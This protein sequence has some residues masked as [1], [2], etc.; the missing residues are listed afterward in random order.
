M[1]ARNRRA[2]RGIV[3]IIVITVLMA[4]IIVAVPFARNM[5]AARKT[6]TTWVQEEQARIAAEGAASYAASVLQASSPMHDTSPLYDATGEFDVRA[7]TSLD[8]PIGPNATSIPVEHVT[9]FPDGG[10]IRIDDEWIEY[11]SIDG[12]NREFKTGPTGTRGAL[13][14]EAVLHKKYAEVSVA[15]KGVR[16]DINVTDEHSRININTLTPDGFAHVMRLPTYEF[17]LK[18]LATTADALPSLQNDLP[19]DTAFPGDPD[20]CDVDVIDIN[21][22]DDLLN[23]IFTDGYGETIDGFLCIDDEWIAY[24]DVSGL[25]GNGDGVTFKDCSRGIR[26]TITR[27]HEAGRPVFVEFPLPVARLTEDLEIRDTDVKLDEVD[28]LPSARGSRRPIPYVPP[29]PAP[30]PIA[31][32]WLRIGDEWLTYYRVTPETA[33]ADL[34]AR[35]GLR[36]GVATELRRNQVEQRRD[37]NVAHAAQELVRVPPYPLPTFLVNDTAIPED[38]GASE[39]TVQVKDATWFPPQGFVNIDGE[40]MYYSNLFISRDLDD[41][42][43]ASA[44]TTDRRNYGEFALEI[45]PQGRGLRGTQR[46]EHLPGAPVYPALYVEE[47]LSQPFDSVEEMRNPTRKAFLEPGTVVNT[48]QTTLSLQEDARRYYF[49]IT[50]TGEV[51]VVQL[52]AETIKYRR[53]VR[54]DSALDLTA[55]GQ[56]GAFGTSPAVHTSPGTVRYLFTYRTAGAD[57]DLKPGTDDRLVDQTE[58]IPPAIFDRIRPYVTTATIAEGPK[59]VPVMFAAKPNAEDA[60]IYHDGTVPVLPWRAWLFFPQGDA[61]ML[62]G[63]GVNYLS[64]DMPQHGTYVAITD[65]SHF[66]DVGRAQ[67]DGREWIRY[68]PTIPPRPGIL[69]QAY[70]ALAHPQGGIVVPDPLYVDWQNAIQWGSDYAAAPSPTPEP[71]DSAVLRMTN[72]AK[73]NINTANAA[74]IMAVCAMA[75]GAASRLSPAD[76]AW[77][78]NAVKSHGVVADSDDLLNNVLDDTDLGVAY[79]KKWLFARWFRSAFAAKGNGSFRVEATGTVKGSRRE[80]AASYTTTQIVEVPDVFPYQDAFPSPLPDPPPLPVLDRQDYFVDWASAQNS[81]PDGTSHLAIIGSTEPFGGVHGLDAAGIPSASAAA[82]AQPGPIPQENDLET[83]FLAN[84]GLSTGIITDSAAY[85]ADSYTRGRLEAV[86]DSALPLPPPPAPSADRVLAE[87]LDC[88]DDGIAYFTSYRM[89]TDGQR[90][91]EADGRNATLAPMAIEMWVKPSA[92]W[93]DAVG[94]RY[95][96]DLHGDAPDGAT[97]PYSNR[98]SLYQRTD[99][100]DEPYLVLDVADTVRGWHARF[101]MQIDSA[102][103]PLPGTVPG[104]LPWVKPDPDDGRWYYLAAVVAGTEPGEMAILVPDPDASAGLAPLAA[105]GTYQIYENDIQTTS[106]GYSYVITDMAKY[107]GWD[108]GDEI[109][110]HGFFAHKPPYVMIGGTRYDVDS[111]SPPASSPAPVQ[112]WDLT[113][114]AIPSPDPTGNTT[115]IPIGMKV[116]PTPTALPPTYFQRTPTSGDKILMLFHDY[117][118]PTPTPTPQPNLNW[119]VEDILTERNIDQ[120]EFDS[121]IDSL[122]WVRL[123]S[124]QSAD[125]FI[126]GP[127]GTDWAERKP[128]LV[129]DDAL[130]GDMP[131][132]VAAT[133]DPANNWTFFTVGCDATG[134]NPGECLIDDLKITRL[135]P[136]YE[137]DTARAP[138]RVIPTPSAAPPATAPD[139]HVEGAEGWPGPTPLRV[140]S[141]LLTPN[142]TGDGAAVVFAESAIPSPTPAPT[143][144]P[145]AF[146]LRI[147]AGDPP[148]H[149]ESVSPLSFLDVGIVDG[150]PVAVGSFLEVPL[151]SSAGFPGSGFVLRQSAGLS[152]YGLFGHVR[153]L[154]DP[155]GLVLWNEAYGAYDTDP[156]RPEAGNVL[157]EFPIRYWDRFPGMAVTGFNEWVKDVSPGLVFRARKRLPG[158]YLERFTWE[159]HNPSGDP[160]DLPSELQGYVNVYVEVLLDGHRVYHSGAGMQLAYYSRPLDPNDDEPWEIN[161]KFDEIEIRAYFDYTG[162]NLTDNAFTLGTCNIAPKIDKFVLYM[163]QPVSTTMVIPGEP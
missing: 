115:K 156:A 68:G 124:H 145:T 128:K 122:L 48:T 149:G 55:P 104:S 25:D 112:D 92:D 94:T 91:I 146:P 110:V 150:A 43:L 138:S 34:A 81:L 135:N 80:T 74:V 22:D 13:N 7:Y 65:S 64:E 60:T 44:F 134:A 37:P 3:L 153:P 84:Y 35:G 102:V 136:L 8:Q 41:N 57:N 24:R 51:G 15:P 54:T 59:E 49:P 147:P 53:P 11:A 27:A 63:L 73:V 9:G 159:Y 10:F 160:E 132:K 4:L 139:I 118:L 18:K 158:G 141:W 95:L 129:L 97:D 20:F 28:S 99:A 151:D 47:L 143:P 85:D 119:E 26:G 5:R 19:E 162:L 133:P 72:P 31:F 148:R 45:P 23:G 83:T 117:C 116:P 69:D 79:E 52:G 163:R 154:S 30:F 121:L 96:F 144:D 50:R 86:T 108:S 66:V 106:P 38:Q 105:Y 6:A 62:T 14:T 2:Q 103:G 109:T 46:A 107:E 126:D 87:G 75:E 142:R 140:R 98:I 40:V 89:T 17:Y 123:D 70:G 161:R 157:T 29:N 111:I 155:E 93:W 88:S 101:E 42:P 130:S 21:D 152:W 56:R 32:G 77:I 33:A 127:D 114:E 58:N 12:T 67:V 78:A 71:Y 39:I 120:R 100:L 76:A 82:C 36:P 137:G 113:L 90:S 1:T 16:W 125:L 131:A 61:R